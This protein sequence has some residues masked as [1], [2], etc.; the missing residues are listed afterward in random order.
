MMEKIISKIKDD[1][2]KTLYSIITRKDENGF[3]NSI[4][5]QTSEVEI[6]HRL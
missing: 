4:G 5:I 1:S 2:L 6:I 3:Y